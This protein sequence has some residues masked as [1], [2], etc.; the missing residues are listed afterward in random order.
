MATVASVASVL[1]NVGRKRLALKKK[2][3][4]SGGFA[5]AAA[6]RKKNLSLLKID[7]GD[8]SPVTF[9]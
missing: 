5:R 3:R 7:V 2:K 8:E 6:R 1:G 4:A 9:A